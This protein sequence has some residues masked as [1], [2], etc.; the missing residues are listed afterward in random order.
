MQNI[1]EK[2][3]QAELLGR[4]GANFPTWLKWKAVKDAKADK[5]YIICNASEGEPSVFKDEYLLKN[6]PTEV[7]N[8]VKIALENISGSFAYIYLRK[9]LYRKF[10]RRLKKIIGESP[11]ELFREPGGY[12]CGEETT[13]IESMEGNRCEPRIKPPYPPQFGFENQPT[14]TNNVETF[15]YAS[16]IAKGEYRK[17]RFFC[18]S[19]KVKNRGVY[20]LPASSTVKEILIK[21]KNLP[22]NK[23]FVQVGGGACGEILA[24]KGLENFVCGAGTIIVYDYKTD[25]IKLMKKWINFYINENCGKCAP[26]REGIYRVKEMLGGKNID[27]DLMKEILETMQKTSFCG[28]GTSMPTAFLS[29][30]EHKNIK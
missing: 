11:I 21:T 4:G 15:Y 1:F 3:K 9:D 23:F 28:L 19:G 20:E 13:L 29:L 25:A 10:K 18:I 2:L 6:Y 27:W 12:L 22:L 16:K 17:T 8:G 26:C 30:M 5:K 24:E 14:L 7:V